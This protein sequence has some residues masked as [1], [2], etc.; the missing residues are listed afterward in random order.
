VVAAAGEF[1]LDIEF[2]SYTKSFKLVTLLA[3]LDAGQLRGGMPLREVALTSRWLVM[4]D[5]RLRN[6]LVDAT[7]A[8]VN[9]ASPSDQEWSSYWRTNPIAAWTSARADGRSPWFELVDGR[10]VPNVDLGDADADVFDTMVREIVDYRIHRYL[11]SKGRLD[12]G[13]RRMPRVDGRTI[14]AEFVVETLDGRPTVVLESAGGTKGT[15]AARNTEYVQGLDVLIERLAALGAQLTSVYLDTAQTKDL[16]VEQRTLKLGMPFPI[17]L[18]LVQPAA[19]RAQMVKAMSGT[20]RS[21]DAGSG[22]GNPRRRIRLLLDGVDHTDCDLAD[23]LAFGVAAA[24]SRL[25]Q[26]AVG[27]ALTSDSGE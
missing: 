12:L 19:L 26:Q 25:A 9:P 5:R 21:E 13:E 1:L 17:D 20:G 27:E 15:A 3:M 24:S 22:G 23:A 4:R 2:G 16:P 6:D 11:R 14:D 18:G 8:F 7:R 10:F